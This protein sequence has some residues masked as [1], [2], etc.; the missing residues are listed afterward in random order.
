MSRMPTSHSELNTSNYNNLD[1]IKRTYLNNQTILQKI[2][3]NNTNNVN[4]NRYEND[5]NNNEYNDK[6]SMSNLN[7]ET[8]IKKERI[9][10]INLPEDN[11]SFKDENS[12]LEYQKEK[13][14]SIINL[15]DFFDNFI[16]SESSKDEMPILM[17]N[18]I[19]DINEY[20]AKLEIKMSKK[21]SRKMYKEIGNDN[22]NK[23]YR[24]NQNQKLVLDKLSKDINISI[25]INK[26]L[27]ERKI[28]K[29]NFKPDRFLDSN[30]SDNDKF[31]LIN[32]SR[33]QKSSGF[34]IS[35]GRYTNKYN[36]KKYNKNNFKYNIIM[37]EFNEK[38]LNN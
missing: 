35:D 30:I 26:Y 37:K 7:T 28:D 2:N 13:E 15:A 27:E 20:R 14:I 36:F 21:E 1:K 29:I 25:D 34:K 10:Q 18:N 23:K 8:N 5:S 11:Y 19:H 32:K 33:R 16:P 4:N 22:L 38:N 12:G 24:P 6:S 9:S 31:K 17:N 3:Y